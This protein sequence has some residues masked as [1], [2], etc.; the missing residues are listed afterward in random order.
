MTLTNEQRRLLKG[1]SASKLVRLLAYWWG[2]DLIMKDAVKLLSKERFIEGEHPDSALYSA[3]TRDEAFERVKRGV[4][5]F[6]PP[7]GWDEHSAADESDWDLDDEDEEDAPDL[8]NADNWHLREPYL[9][10]IED[11]PTIDE[12]FI[13]DHQVSFKGELVTLVKRE[14][15]SK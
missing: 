13:P 14:Q 10:F 9:E 12:R 5:H 7:E 4:Y 3:V 8:Q 2:G 15:A 11:E 1:K 6:T